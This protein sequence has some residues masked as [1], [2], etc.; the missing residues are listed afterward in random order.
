MGVLDFVVTRKEGELQRQTPCLPSCLAALYQNISSVHLRIKCC[1]PV[2]ISP[3]I[4]GS[5]VPWQHLPVN[6]IRVGSHHQASQNTSGPHLHLVM[7]YPFYI[8]SLLSFLYTPGFNLLR[9]LLRITIISFF[10]NCKL[11]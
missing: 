8:L 9:V 1:Q 10:E 3:L 4:L 6:S 11:V 5:P 7:S 2:S